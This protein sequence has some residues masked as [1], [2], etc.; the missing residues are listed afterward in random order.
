MRLLKN[1]SYWLGA[2]AVLLLGIAGCGPGGTIWRADEP[3]SSV[4]KEVS[5]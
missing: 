1:R 2:F 4:A 5:R 3:A